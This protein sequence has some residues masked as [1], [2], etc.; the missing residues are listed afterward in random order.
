MHADPGSRT[1]ASIVIVAY[2]QRPVTERCLAILDRTLGPDLGRDFEL[3][4]VDNDSP[5]DTRELFEAWSDRATVLKLDSNRN[6]S[7]GCNAGARAARGRTLIF[8]NN[9]VEAWEG[10]LELLVEQ[11]A[12]PGVG[13]VGARLL[14]P[15]DTIQHAGVGMIETPTGLVV[16][17]HLFHHEAGDLPAARARFDLDAVTGACMAVPRDL[18]LELGGFDEGFANGW[19]DVDLCLR[20]RTTGKRVVYRG[21]IALGHD[22]GRTRGS[23]RGADRNAQRFYARWRSVLADDSELVA[24]VFDGR[25]PTGRVQASPSRETASVC[26]EG[27]LTG[28]SPQADEARALLSA[29]ELAGLTPAARDLCRALVEPSLE[30]E[31][32]AAVD[33]A[34]SRL[35]SSSTPGVRVPVGRL[36]SPPSGDP[37]LRLGALPRTTIPAGTAVWAASPALVDELIDGGLSPGCVD[38]VPSP[39]DLP[40]LAPGGDGVLATLPADDV[41]LVQELLAALAPFADLRLRLLPSFASGDLAALA[42]RSLPNAELLSPCSS[43]RRLSALVTGADVVVSCDRSDPFERRA[44]LAAASGAAAVT[45]ARGPAASVLGD[46]C[47]VRGRGAAMDLTS[48]VERSLELASGRAERAR[49]VAESCNP[50]SFATRLQELVE[51]SKGEAIRAPAFPALH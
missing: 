49:A 27:Q 17:H 32:L 38:H 41:P 3:V 15:D 28:I 29:A 43:E 8:L 39:I 20:I 37:I 36:W 35:T 1:S 23:V 5:D 22:E 26:I 4:L 47:S 24:Q 16:P 2:G 30:D 40:P 25:F 13:A 9:D 45:Y 46:S 19:E 7:G 42:S 18:F 50:N 21:D 33:S 48:A 34:R 44:L 12:V 10:A 6:F 51:G 11:A 31:E 14:Y